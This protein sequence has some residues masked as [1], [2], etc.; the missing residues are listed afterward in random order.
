MN[1]HQT[2]A[3]L[4]CL[5]RDML[6]KAK[7]DTVTLFE[8]SLSQTSGGRIDEPDNRNCRHVP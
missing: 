2:V 7:H 3:A 4:T 1:D 6:A 5:G 8:N